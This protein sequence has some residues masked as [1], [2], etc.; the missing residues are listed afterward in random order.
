[1]PG[2]FSQAA[3]AVQRGRPDMAPTSYGA[4]I[5]R[6][7]LQLGF[8]VRHVLARHRVE[9]HEFELLG[10]GALVLAGGVEVAGAREDSSLI[11]SRPPFAMSHPLAELSA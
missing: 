11:F 2:F 5:M 3:T 4:R 1:M 6:R 8:L 7:L 10:L 9:L